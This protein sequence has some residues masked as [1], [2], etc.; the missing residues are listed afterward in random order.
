MID[1]NLASNLDA[2][3]KFVMKY[4]V[5]G[6]A[7]FLDDYFTNFGKGEAIVAEMCA[8]LAAEAGWKLIDHSFYAPFA[9][10]FILAR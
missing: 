2:S 3:T 10:S 4:A 1:C 6:C 7:V 9:K 5:P 8:R